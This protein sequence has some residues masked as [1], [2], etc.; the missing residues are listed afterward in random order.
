MASD[1][2]YK[3]ADQ[4][5]G[6][7]TFRDLVEMVREEQLTADVLVRPHYTNEWQRADEVVGLFHMARRDPATLPAVQETAS[8]QVDENADAEDLESFS[9]TSEEPVTQE[10]V[11]KPGWLK[12]LLSLRSSKIPAVP[13]DPNCEINIDLSQP[14][15]VDS[16]LETFD[17]SVEF[18][19]ENQVASSGVDRI[20]TTEESNSHLINENEAVIGAYSND[21]WSSAIGAAVERVDARAPKQEE[22]SPPKQI[23]PA[24]TFSFLDSPLFR[25]TVQASAIILCASLAIYA[26][27]DWMGQGTLYFPFIGACSPLLFLVYSAATFLAI[28]IL[29][30]LLVYFSSAYLRIGYRLG[31][32]I[33]TTNVT[34]YYL[35]TWPQDKVVVFPT[36]NPDPTE[37]IMIFPIMGECSSFAYWMYFFDVVLFVA[38]LTYFVA[39]WLEA[40]ADDV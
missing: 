7:Y 18:D 15:T 39:W 23:V 5:L 10:E 40:H 29:A 26:F 11:K 32:V 4:E 9:S 8:E 6:P 25:K 30:P 34:I 12:R 22:E 16:P 13:L 28:L 38:V 31:A 2:Y 36:Q 17:E 1:W 3:Q 24:I 21:T 14:V 20:D 27:V 19:S 35:L 33:I 37:P